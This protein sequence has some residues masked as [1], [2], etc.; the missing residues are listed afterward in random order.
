[1]PPMHGSCVSETVHRETVHP[2]YWGQGDIAH[3]ATP[4]SWM[5]EC[6]RGRKMISAHSNAGTHLQIDLRR[7]RRRDVPG[8]GEAAS[9]W[10]RD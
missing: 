6:D 1:M 9:R 8:R 7:I 2:K 4:M 3:A 10:N 5:T